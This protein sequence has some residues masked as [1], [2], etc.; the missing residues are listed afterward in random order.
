MAMAVHVIDGCNNTLE[1]TIPITVETPPLITLPAVIA[2][3][4]AP[5]TAQFPSGLT[6]QP[7]TWLWHL[8]DGST[9]TAQAPTH[10]YPAGTYTVSLTVTTPLGCSA[11][12]ANTG[13]V[14]SYATPT[15]AFTA[16]P[17]ETDVDHANIQFTDQSSGSV[18]AWSWSFGDGGA[19][20]N[21]S[22]EHQ[23]A[24]PGTWNVVLQ[25]TD[26]HGCTGSVAHSVLVNPVYDITIPNAFTPNPNGGSGGSFDP[27][28]LSNDVFYPFIRFVK[29]F[30][31]RV[32][33]RWG[34][35]V[36]E[37]N[38]I[39][40]GWDGYYRGQLSPQDVYVYQLW[41]RFTDDK[42]MQRTGDL[43]LL[44]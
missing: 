17:W 19:S 29:E 13:M 43:T 44:R 15:A 27:N 31:M 22:P 2:E 41:V 4:C 42:E 6:N 14:Y 10:V 12:A 40:Q 21:P 23:F 39:K 7:V 24:E 30:R 18:S 11:P 38:D 20:T 16:S 5:L 34:E 26:D 9:S 28:D 36:F 8:G 3:G 33:N 1:Q 32:F 37:S 35:L 25:V